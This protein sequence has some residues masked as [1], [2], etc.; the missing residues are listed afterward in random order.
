[1]KEEGERKQPDRGGT[2]IPPKASEVL[3]I[4]LFMLL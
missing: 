1:M 3:P 2:F 4:S